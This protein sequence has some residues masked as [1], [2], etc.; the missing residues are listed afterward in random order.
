MECD[1]TTTHKY[2]NRKEDVNIKV[3]SEFFYRLK[4]AYLPKCKPLFL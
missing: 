2:D 4:L 3:A 1:Y